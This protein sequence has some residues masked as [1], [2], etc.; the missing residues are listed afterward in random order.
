M[1]DFVGEFNGVIAQT[2]SA[3]A[4]ELNNKNITAKAGL[5][6]TKAILC[7]IFE[8]RVGDN[9]TSKT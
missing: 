2:G 5:R 8:K 3:L 1:V 7:N 9:L 6:I 4:V